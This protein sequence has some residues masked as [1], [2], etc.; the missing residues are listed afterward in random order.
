MNREYIRMEMYKIIGI[1]LVIT[2]VVDIIVLPRIF[3]RLEKNS[4]LITA[5]VW[6]FAVTTIILGTL[7]LLG[8]FGEF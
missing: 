7:C 6:L 8:K 1:I 2:G 4:T 3:S 5:I